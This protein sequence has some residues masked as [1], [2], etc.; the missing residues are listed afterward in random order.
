MNQT[1][2]KVLLSCGLFQG[3]ANPAGLLGCL[4]GETVFYGK[5]EIIWHIGDPIHACAVILS[6]AVRAES[7]NASGAHT[8][9]AYHRPGALV[10]DILMATPGGKSPVYVTAAENTTVV[11]LP[12]ERMMGGCEKCCPAHVR[13]RE[14][15]ISEI[16]QK[17]WMQRRRMGYLSC[18]SLRGRIAAYL[19][20]RSRDADSG[21]FSLGGTREDM[22]DYL[23]VNRSAM[24]RELGRMKAEGLLDY[25]RD[26]F[27]LLQPEALQHLVP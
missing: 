17:Y 23:C 25:Y 12:F 27:R 15:L 3:I 2:E 7:V 6:G 11:F 13:L 1:E 24:S 14:N 18:N 26:S 8:L 21:T 9:M 5:N 4:H 20:D 22:A 10:G 16:A 19:L